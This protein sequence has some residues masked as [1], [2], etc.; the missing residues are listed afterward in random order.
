MSV[1]GAAV[2]DP[3]AK[4]F[5]DDLAN[6][7][8]RGE[9]KAVGPLIKVIDRLDKHQETVVVKHEYGPEE[10]RRLLDKINRVVANLAPLPPK[11]DLPAADERE[12]N[13]AE[14]PA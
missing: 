8:S 14:S 13:S 9:L 12:N 5:L 6:A 11:P 10:R 3:L 2:D 7:I 4:D 1:I